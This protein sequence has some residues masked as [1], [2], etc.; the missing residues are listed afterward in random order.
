[1]NLDFGPNELFIVPVIL[2]N[3]VI[4]TRVVNLMRTCPY[5]MTLTLRSYLYRG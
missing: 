3:I 4:E 5:V 2:D 1:M